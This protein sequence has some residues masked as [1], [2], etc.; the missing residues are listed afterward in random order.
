MYHHVIQYTRCKI[1]FL[2]AACVSADFVTVF[3]TV[4]QCWNFRTIS[5]GLG[6]E[7]SYWAASICILAGR[8]DNL[9]P[10]RFLAPI[11]CYKIPA[12]VYTLY[13]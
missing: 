6:T 8:Y 4:E 3:V 1:R 9:V 12:E 5:G 2:N 13:L 11:D 7:L 10:T